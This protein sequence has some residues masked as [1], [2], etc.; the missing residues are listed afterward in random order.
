MSNGSVVVAGGPDSIPDG[1]VRSRA[2]SVYL[3]GPMAGQS[4]VAA[5]TWRADVAERLPA[6]DFLNPMRGRPE[7]AEA[8]TL[9]SS[10][11]G[12]LLDERAVVARDL[13]DIEHADVVLFNLTAAESA[14]VGTMVEYG[15]AR[16]LGKFL[17]VVL[18]G[19]SNPHHHPF[20]RELAHVTVGCLDDAISVLADL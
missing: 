19:E 18:A 1:R 12:G 13:R 7:L 3:A 16:A 6:I 15:F 17:L 14:S 8:E 9:G 20:V 11:H 10:R 2:L 5:A 4:F